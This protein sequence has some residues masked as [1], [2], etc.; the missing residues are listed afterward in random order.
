MVYSLKTAD[1][2]LRPEMLPD[3]RE[4]PEAS[5]RARCHYHVPAAGSAPPQGRAPVP[6]G[7][8]GRQGG[9]GRPAEQLQ[10]AATLPLRKPPLGIF[11]CFQAFFLKTEDF[12]WFNV[13]SGLGKFRPDL[14]KALEKVNIDST[15]KIRSS[16]LNAN[17]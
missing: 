6:V 17:C 13:T 11:V 1:S 16:L 3:E 12:K 15:M 5:K 4:R 7:P 8:A 2:P 9:Q 14:L 10:A